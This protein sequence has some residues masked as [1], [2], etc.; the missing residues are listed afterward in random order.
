[1]HEL[2]PDSS[3]GQQPVERPISTEAPTSR[4]S[5]LLPDWNE[6]QRKAVVIALALH[7]RSMAQDGSADVRNTLFSASDIV[8]RI[9]TEDSKF[10]EANR[11]YILRDLDEARIVEL[12][13]DI[14]QQPLF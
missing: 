8:L 10:L 4:E 13:E 6:N 14:N 12:L 11:D 2:P 3:G 1:M 5:R 9:M 7:M